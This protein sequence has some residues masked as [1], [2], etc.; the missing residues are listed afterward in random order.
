MK[1]C[2]REAVPV[3]DQSCDGLMSSL[4]S[5]IEVVTRSERRRW[6]AA[7]KLRIVQQTLEPGAAVASVA[8]RHG[9]APALLYGWRKRALAGAMSGF[10]PVQVEAD[11]ERAPSSIVAPAPAEAC[12][13]PGSAP[14]ERGGVIELELPNGC[15]VR[16]GSDVDGAALRRVLGALGHRG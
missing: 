3:C 11:A 2:A 5:T 4:S 14:S 10:L 16:V 9:L 8:Q 15:R 13:S 12:S 6:S 1:R 7:E